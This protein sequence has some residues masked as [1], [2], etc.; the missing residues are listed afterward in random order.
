[1]VIASAKRKRVK[2][3]DI[4]YQYLD[5]DGALMPSTG[6]KEDAQVKHG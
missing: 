2:G 6:K 4:H 1:M 5:T 3:R